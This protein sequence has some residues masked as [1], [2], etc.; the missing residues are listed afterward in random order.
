MYLTV[1]QQVKHLSKTSYRNL[2]RLS[3]TAKNLMNEALYLNRQHFFTESK[4]LGYE[5]TYAELKSS[6]NYKTLNSHMAQQT[7]R[8]VDSMFQSF[9]GLLKLV[10][11][12]RYDYR[13]VKLPNYL[14]KDGYAPLFIQQ[15]KIRDGLLTLPYSKRFARAHPKIAV[16]VPPILDGKRVKYIKIIPICN[17][18]FFE[19]QYVLVH[20]RRQALK[21]FQSMVQQ[22]EFILVQRQRQATLRQ[23]ADG[24]TEVARSKAS[25]S[26]ERLHIENM[27]EGAQLLFGAA[28]R[29]ID[30]RLQCYIST[31]LEHGQSD[32]SKLCQHTVRQNPRE[33]AILVS[34]VRL[35]VH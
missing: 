5:K 22:K 21:I 9:I 24:T 32:E 27:S 12:K 25:S 35:E 20:H 16:R 33:V 15:F 18:K 11:Q 30:L 17:A 7:L 23:E 3:R 10:K 19:I 4:Y 1:K 31:A 8:A 28:A 26:G 34:K 13:A 29:N 6:P 2:R 14:P